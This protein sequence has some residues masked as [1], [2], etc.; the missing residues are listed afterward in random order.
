[1]AAE[2]VSLFINV[3]GKICKFK[4]SF[5]SKGKVIS[6]CSKGIFDCVVTNGNTYTDC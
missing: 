2:H 3:N 6:T 1:M 5:A 4:P